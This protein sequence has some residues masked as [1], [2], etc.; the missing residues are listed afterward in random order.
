MDWGL[1]KSLTL[2]PA[3]SALVG[4]IGERGSVK[5]QVDAL[6]VLEVALDLGDGLNS[7]NHLGVGV[8]VF[9]VL[10]FAP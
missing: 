9:D 1:S 10:V 6:E 4:L 5:T 3:S 8:A 2:A 7:W